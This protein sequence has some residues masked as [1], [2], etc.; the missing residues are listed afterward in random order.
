[1][2]ARFKCFNNGVNFI[3]NGNDLLPL[4]ALS[5]SVL[6][7]TSWRCL[8][9]QLSDQDKLGRRKPNIKV[10]NVDLRGDRS[11]TLRHFAHQRR[12]LDESSKAG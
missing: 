5:A 10:W 9:R 3:A 8:R 2:W 6:R 12:L 7:T 11:L 4:P 1:M